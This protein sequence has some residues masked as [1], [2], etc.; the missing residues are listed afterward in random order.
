MQTLLIQQMA[1]ISRTSQPSFES[2]ELFGP[3]RSRTFSLFHVNCIVS[4]DCKHLLFTVN[5]T[6]RKSHTYIGVV[7]VSHTQKKRADEKLF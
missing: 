2:F 5:A 7:W 4:Q 6:P 3:L 1:R